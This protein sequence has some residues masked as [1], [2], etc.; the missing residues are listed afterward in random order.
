[1]F[2]LNRRTGAAAFAAS[3]LAATALTVTTTPATAIQGGQNTTV[4]AHPYSMLL[5]T[6]S[7]EQLCGGTLVAPTKVL[8]AAHCIDP[9]APLDLVVVGGRT[10]LKSAKGTVRSVKSVKIH[11]KY[12]A[13]WLGFDAAVLSLSAPMPYAPLPIASSKD[14]ALYAAGRTAKTMGWGKT[15]TNTPGTR[16]KSAVLTQAPLKSCGP[17]IAPGD[18][19]ATRV[20]A[21]P[22]VGTKDGICQGD[23]GGPLV[24]G[25]RLIGIVSTGN[26]F[27]D[28]FLPVSV[29]TRAS[30]V[31]AG[32]G[33]PTA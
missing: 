12:D 10:E 15:A 30:T 11:P 18:T 17:Y 24:A 3:V 25:G 26:K 23:S 29:Y 6:P 20:C 9:A 32:L 2:T 1:M 13:T 4:V 19:S 7:G 5:L 14:S 27:C 8:T 28:D 33:L 21:V 31:A 22:G 16:L